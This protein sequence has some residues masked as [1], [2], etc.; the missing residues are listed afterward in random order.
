MTKKRILIA[1][2]LFIA[3]AGAVAAVI[4]SHFDFSAQKT[5][6]DL[7]FMDE[8]GTGIIAEQHEIRYKTGYDFVENTIDE[9]RKGPSVSKHGK[10]MSSDTSLVNIGFSAAEGEGVTVDFSSEYLTD[11]PSKNVLSTYAVVKSLCSIGWISRVRVTVNGNDITDADGN[12]LGYIAAS[13]INLETEEYSSELRESIL[14]FADS[15]NKKLV[16]EKRMI[17]ITDQ[18]PIEQYIINELIK[19]P[20]NDELHSVL[21]DDTVLMSVDVEDNICYLNFKSSFI[22]ENTGDGMHEQLVIY[23]I[24]NSLTEL[25]T[26]NRVQFYMDGKRVNAFG[27]FNLKDY[28]SRDTS[29]IQR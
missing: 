15:S 1:V 11:N 6:V 4:L 8:S 29:I 16:Q 25:K 22:S 18:Q 12:N 9:L 23:S 27:S 7:Y 5:S 13:D 26:I 17:K 3:V 24:V 14:Y 19:G 2:L 28:I 21:S 20:V 10:I